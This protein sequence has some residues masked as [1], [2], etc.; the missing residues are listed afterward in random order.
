MFNRQRGF[1]DTR[2]TGLYENPS[3]T[4]PNLLIGN[5]SNNYPTA[6]SLAADLKTAYVGSNYDVND[7][8]YFDSDPI[9]KRVTA[10]VEK[11]Y[12]YNGGTKS[13]LFWIDLEN[14]NTDQSLGFWYNMG[15][16]RVV[17]HQGVTDL[18]QMVYNSTFVQSVNVPN[19]V[20]TGTSNNGPF[21]AAKQ[22]YFIYAPQLKKFLPAANYD[23]NF[24]FQIKTNGTIWVH[25]DMATAQNGSMDGNLAYLQNTKGWTVNYG[26]HPTFEQ[27]PNPVT[28]LE[29]ISVTSNSVTLNFSDPEAVNGI[30]AHQLFNGTTYLQNLTAGT[31]VVTGLNSGTQYG[32]EILTFDNFR[33]IMPG[34]PVK[35]TTL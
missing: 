33:N 4:S 9:T 24:F 1:R 6:A 13:F 11:D 17:K 30:L 29:V 25:P 18:G 5:A 20:S 3:L 27:F 32:F 16:L 31:T 21:R 23:G 7:I 28:D 15:A 22:V 35:F 19:L 10:R 2:R 12:R 14:K 8:T 34:N 26:T